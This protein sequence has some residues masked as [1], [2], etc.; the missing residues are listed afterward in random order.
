MTRRMTVVPVLVTP[1]V[2]LVLFLG[3][4]DAA[5]RG[6]IKGA[7]VGAVAGH[8]V[9]H[10][11]VVGAVAG[12]AIGHHAAKKKE[13]QLR[14]QQSGTPAQPPSPNSGGQPT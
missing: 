3:S 5:A 12:C 10:H 9:G 4:H 13:Q 6:C 8:V 11:A 7:A 14:Q 1:L 2:S